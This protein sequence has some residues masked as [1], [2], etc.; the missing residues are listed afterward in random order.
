MDF[1]TIKEALKK[2][3][4]SDLNSSIPGKLITQKAKLEK[5]LD[6][7]KKKIIQDKINKLK[8]QEMQ[9]KDGSWLLEP[10]ILY[11]PG[12]PAPLWPN[13]SLHEVLDHDPVMTKIKIT[14][15]QNNCAE[16]NDT[17]STPVRRQTQSTK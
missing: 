4:E 9:I 10:I 1:E 5:G 11:P 12:P 7:K 17:P 3:G 15:K 13:S 8:R 2:K 14:L 16:E 6:E